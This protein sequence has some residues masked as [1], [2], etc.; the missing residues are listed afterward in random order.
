MKSKKYNLRKISRF[1]TVHIIFFKLLVSEITN[2][3]E[4][5]KLTGKCSIHIL[6]QEELLKRF[7]E[8]QDFFAEVKKA[9]N[10]NTNKKHIY[11]IEELNQPENQLHLIVIEVINEKG[12]GVLRRCSADEILSYLHCSMLILGIP[13]PY[14][15]F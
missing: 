15:L 1:S 10:K 11:R 14:H 13:I 4:H 7:Q 2:I 9:V 5:E 8:Q 3:I 12:K 6:V